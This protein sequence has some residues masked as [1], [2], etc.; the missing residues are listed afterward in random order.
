[1]GSLP[2]SGCLFRC[3]APPRYVSISSI[4]VLFDVWATCGFRAICKMQH[5]GTWR[6]LTR[7]TWR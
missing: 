7:L 6:H 3:R 2:V 4:F 5:S 1:M